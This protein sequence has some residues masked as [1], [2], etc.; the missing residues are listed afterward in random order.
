M[1]DGKAWGKHG[2]VIWWVVPF[3][4]DIKGIPHG[5]GNGYAMVK[6]DNPYFNETPGED[7]VVHGGITFNKMV[8][9]ITR[10]LWVPDWILNTDKR[11]Y[12]FD[13]GHYGDDAYT[14]DCRYVI[15]QA[16]QLAAQ[17]DDA[18][19]RKDKKPPLKE[20]VSVLSAYDEYVRAGQP[21]PAFL[22][23]V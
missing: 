7:V 3:Q 10:K 6:P 14:C 9:D 1:K 23:G 12:G 15:K 17:L 8:S 18:K 21:I 20:E 19:R 13:T 2:E 22:K 11:A 16:Q 5:W 4:L